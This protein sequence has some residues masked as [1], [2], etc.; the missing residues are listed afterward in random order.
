MNW[1]NKLPF[2]TTDEL[3]HTWA[4]WKGKRAGAFTSFNQKKK[5]Q[6]SKKEKD[7]ICRRYNTPTGC[8]YDANTCKTFYGNKLRHVCNQNMPGGGK[9]GKDHPRH[10]H[11]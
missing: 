2:L 3:A 5:E 7:D 4:A 1:E 8:Q 10:E 6:Q 11:K 9:C